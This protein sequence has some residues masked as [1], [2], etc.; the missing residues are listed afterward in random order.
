M[1][2]IKI[3]PFWGIYS[4]IGGDFKPSR[5][6]V[7]VCYHLHLPLVKCIIIECVAHFFLV[8]YTNYGYCDL[9]LYKNL[10]GNETMPWQY[11]LMSR[12]VDFI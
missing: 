4:S 10:N 7:F 5:P 6:Y 11:I 3:N 2:A 8:K 9:I 12:D 1:N